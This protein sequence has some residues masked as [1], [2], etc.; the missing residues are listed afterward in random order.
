MLYSRAVAGEGLL[1]VGEL[2]KRSGVSPELLRAWE[3]RY[4]LLQPTR[5]TGGLRLYSP[6]DLERVRRMQKHLAEGLAAAEAACVAVQHVSSEEAPGA[7]LPP[8]AL[9]EELSEALERFDEPRAQ[10]VLDRLLAATTVD[11][12]LTDVVIVRSH[13]DVCLL[14]SEGRFGWLRSTQRRQPRRA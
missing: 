6:T 10:S 14:C 5:S 3:R 8:T 1:R 4:G 13:A 9:R 7:A 11:T 12:L 2:S